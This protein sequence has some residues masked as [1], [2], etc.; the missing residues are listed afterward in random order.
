MLADRYRLE[1]RIAFG[2]VGEVWRAT[3]LVLDRA[4]AVKLLRDG[5][6]DH[7]ETLTRFRA[8]ARH[9]GSLAHPGI[10]KVYD[11]GEGTPPDSP[12]LVMELVDGPSLAGVLTSGPL[13]AARTMD[14]VA[15]AAAGLA[16]AH[17]AG[18][19][20]RDIKP[21]NLLVTP[22]GMVKITDFGIAHA[23]GSAPLTQTGALVGT[24]DY[25]A[26]ERAEGAPATPA[27]DLYSLGVVAYECLVG[28]PPFDGAPLEVVVAHQRRPLP[29]L[30]VGVPAEVAALV[31]H[32]TAK[33]PAARPASA[34]AVA[35][36]AGHL[37]DV[38]AGEVAPGSAAPG[39][40]APG[41]AASSTAMGNAASG[42]AMGSAASGAVMG[43]A[44]IGA[45]ETGATAGSG[46]ADAVAAGSVTTG[47]G[48]DASHAFG[49]Q[50]PPPSASPPPAGPAAGHATLAGPPLSAPLGRAGF[51]RAG[52][53][54][55]GFGRRPMTLTLAAV[56]IIAVLAI[57]G[58]T[59][60]L[61]ASGAGQHAPH[62]AA[63]PPRPTHSASSQPP[64]H[65][66]HGGDDE[67]G[68]GDNHGGGRGEGHGNGGG[69]GHGNGDGNGHGNGNGD[70]GGDG[71]GNGSGDGNGQGN[72]GG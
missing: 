5:Y 67:R 66:R 41:N 1:S 2:G 35:A 71:N 17:A 47:S 59:G 21:A 56:A 20:H 10:A 15:Q 52:F 23:A 16:A 45:A 18:L 48:D 53:G 72:D 65:H 38:A 64:P 26:P 9:A 11:Y 25:L 14:V 61:V 34:E 63:V 19:V 51:G 42:A 50:V 28:A 49:W 32:L 54:R 43:S 8:E 22:D 30:P 4:V 58:L 40:V 31:T 46:A 57:A 37:R 29:L 6:A 39:E 44:A 33:D 55:A 13:G 24:P 60:W 36:R 68:R 70:G 7:P 62:R 69:N 3:D 27:T 12:Y